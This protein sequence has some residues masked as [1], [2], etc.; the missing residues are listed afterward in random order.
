MIIKV[1]VP[2]KLKYLYPLII[3]KSK[4]YFKNMAI[5]KNRI[6]FHPQKYYFIF[7]YSRCLHFEINHLSDNV[8]HELEQYLEYLFN[9]DYIGIEKKYK[10][11]FKLENVTIIEI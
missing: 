7:I 5:Y 11:F 8:I 9:S 4:K 10:D 2:K 3:F 6:I 1:I